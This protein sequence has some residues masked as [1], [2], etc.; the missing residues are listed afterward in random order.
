[1]LTVTDAAETAF[2]RLRKEH[3]TQAILINWPSEIGYETLDHFKREATDAE[4][5]VV[6]GCPVYIDS[7]QLPRVDQVGVVLDLAAGSTQGEWPEP[8]VRPAR[9]GDPT[10]ST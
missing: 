10:C 7:R 8:T 4:I 6:A 5:G 3:G 9:P 2:T 1:M